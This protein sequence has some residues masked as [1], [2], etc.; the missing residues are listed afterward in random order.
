MRYLKID[1]LLPQFI[2][3]YFCRAN[4]Y[5]EYAVCHWCRINS[6]RFMGTC[7]IRHSRIFIRRV[8]FGMPH[9]QSLTNDYCLRKPHSRRSGSDCKST[10]YIV[11]PLLRHSTTAKYVIVRFDLTGG[12]V[13]VTI[14]SVNHKLLFLFTEMPRICTQ[15]KPLIFNEN[16]LIRSGA[17]GDKQ[18]NGCPRDRFYS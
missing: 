5:F 2:G 1:L 12:F 18:K 9:L 10:F 13:M 8:Y 14:M 6:G 16:R 4:E 3:R 11:R 17:T 7:P 15:K